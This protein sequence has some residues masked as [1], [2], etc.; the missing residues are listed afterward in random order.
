VQ[1]PSTPTAPAVPRPTLW[2]LVVAYLV[3]F[4]LV[5]TTSTAYILVAVLLHA[6]GRHLD[7]A[8]LADATS[9]F[10]LSPP[11]LFGAAFVSAAVLA[12]VS[13]VTA[14]LLQ[15]QPGEGAVVQLR[16]GRTPA[17]AAGIGAAVVGMAGLSLACG[18]ASDLVGLSEKGVMGS[19]ALV[20]TA[21][22]P[23][24]LVLALLTIGVAPALAEEGFFRGLF[25]TRLRARWGR[26][27]AIVLTAVAFGVFHLDPIQG[28]FACFAGI[29]LGWVVERFGGIRPT[30]I[31]HGVNNALFVLLGSLQAPGEHATRTTSLVTLVAGAATCAAAIAVLRSRLAVRA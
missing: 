21:S 2:P 17:S 4:V 22:T 31:A 27:P 25:Q 10:A 20:L 29:F 12:G 13:A 23:L 19:I 7:V 11:G 9:Q 8:G 1:P 5:F 18:A 16:L 3:A 6:R 24:H 30:I 28:T 26:W 14:R 15:T